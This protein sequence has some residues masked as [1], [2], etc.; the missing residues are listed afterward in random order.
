MG[1]E[2]KALPHQISTQGPYGPIRVVKY[3]ARKKN[4]LGAIVSLS[5]PSGL[6]LHDCSVH[7]GKNGRRWIGLPAKPFMNNDGGVGWTPLVEIPDPQRRECFY[8]QAL[9]AIDEYVSANTGES[10]R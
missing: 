3:E 8:L 5:L 9:A 6:L 2:A 10:E 7:E 1:I 4:T